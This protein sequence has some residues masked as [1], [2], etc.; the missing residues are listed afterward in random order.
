MFVW[1][2]QVKLA[3]PWLV[4]VAVTVPL[5]PLAMVPVGPEQVR[6][7]TV[8][9][10]DWLVQVLGKHVAPAPT[11]YVLLPALQVT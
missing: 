6:P 8:Q 2:L 3:V 7:P 4:P 9:E 11:V 1:L 10:R 5:A